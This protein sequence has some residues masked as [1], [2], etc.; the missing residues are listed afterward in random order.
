MLDRDFKAKLCDFGLVTQLTH[1]ITSRSTEV[2]I[3]TQAY[4]DPSCRQNKKMSKESDVYSFGVLLLEVVCGVRP[5]LTDTARENDLIEM[6][7]GCEAGNAILDA[8]DKRLGREHDDTI[9]EA[10]LLGLRCVKTSRGD[11]PVTDIVLSQLSSMR[12]R[13]L[14]C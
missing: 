13:V 11:R 5:I 8:A 10:L 1:V 6:V 9:K 3:G 4:M 12:S 14:K 7:R 2:V